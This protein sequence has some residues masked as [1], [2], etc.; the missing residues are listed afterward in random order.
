MRTLLT[1]GILV[2]T[3]LMVWFTWPRPDTE[4]QVAPGGVATVI[5][6]YGRRHP[7]GDTIFVG[8]SGARRTIRVVNND[9][10]AHRLAM[11]NVGPG[12][13]TEYTVPPGTF[14]GLCTA[15]PVATQLTFVIR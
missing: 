15:H 7:L 4:I 8:G 11:F 13:R 3:G 9:S 6:G 1:L 2:L 5:D 12:E 14:G 10:S